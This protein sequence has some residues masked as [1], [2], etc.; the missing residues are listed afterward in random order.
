L[1]EKVK[2]KSISNY[3]W[4]LNTVLKDLKNKTLSKVIFRFLLFSLLI[5]SYN[6][7]VVYFV[8]YSGYKYELIYNWRISPR[9][10]FS[11]FLF[12]GFC[13]FPFLILKRKFKRLIMLFY[14]PLPLL[15]IFLIWLAIHYNTGLNI[16]SLLILENSNWTETSEFI[17]INW[18]IFVWLLISYW[19]YYLWFKSELNIEYSRISA[20]Y[21]YL[22]I[23]AFLLP[24]FYINYSKEKNLTFEVYNR[25]FPLS[26]VGSYKD[27]KKFHDIRVSFF[28]SKEQF[29]FG[30]IHSGSLDTEI[31][32]L[33][34]GE[35]ARADHFGLNDYIPNTTPL[36]KKQ[37]DLINFDNAAAQASHTMRALPMM[38]TRATPDNYNLSFKEKSL[39]S[40][41][42][43]AG[44]ETSWISSIPGF[45]FFDQEVYND[46]HCFEASKQ[47]FCEK[48]SCDD[49]LIVTEF[50][51]QLKGIKAGG[52]YFFVLHG[53][54]SHIPYDIRFPKA[55]DKFNASE[56]Q[57]INDYDNSILYTDFIINEIITSLNK[58]FAQSIL[59]YTSDH[60]ENLED[61]SRGLMYHSYT[62]TSYASHVPFFIWHNE[63]YKL[64]NLNYIQN[65]KKNSSK[66]IS[67][68]NVFQTLLQ[69][70][71]ISYSNFEC[72]KS[73]C[74]STFI[75]SEQLIYF[76]ES[77][78]IKFSELKDLDATFKK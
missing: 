68:D 46:V 25:Y 57:I 77:K 55:F 1:K 17:F 34:I 21:S 41:Y 30:A 6:L 78:S 20:A 4:D 53:Y 2:I 56:N 12:S 14:L 36:L 31:Y 62:P 63:K 64:N 51:K 10:L 32:V 27:Y 52:K 47:S 59:L 70:S 15:N 61:D 26:L 44:F 54:G 29:S 38:L 66:K 42:N 75:E 24:S 28:K 69:L 7:I 16:D 58:T 50:K 74:D 13:Y 35:S 22:L 72:Y 65:L 73:I 45:V 43:E 49:L 60:G 67:N 9:P 3:F 76:N 40:A 8:S 71:H 5:S 39:I 37:K 11:F 19:L 23:I 18:Q 33:F 48:T